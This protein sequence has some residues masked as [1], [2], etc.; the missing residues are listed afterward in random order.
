M[1]LAA[2]TEK[3]R[4]MSN[5]ASTTAPELSVTWDEVRAQLRALI[6]RRVGDPEAVEDLVQEVL[7]RLSAAATGDEPIRN[8]SQWLNRVARNATIDY[9]RTRRHLDPIEA[10]AQ[11]A[12]PSAWPFADATDDQAARE[13]SHCLR[14]LL[15]RLPDA[16]REALVL[17]DLDGLTQAAA[18]TALG[19]SFSGMKSRV[20]RARHQLRA[21]LVA[22]CPVLLDRR[23]TIVDYT[24]P[25]RSCG[26][27]NPETRSLQAAIPSS[28]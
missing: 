1:P 3:D 24:P 4:S 28:P 12:D 13:L 21:L 9:Y 5:R 14:P 10:A 2:G 7:L 11:V 23:G 16:S 26:C 8:V 20:Q 15:E 25:A 22:C 19:L 27:A 17:T 18:A 6:G